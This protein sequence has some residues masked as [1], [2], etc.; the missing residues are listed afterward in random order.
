M[1]YEASSLCAPLSR[2]VPQGSI[3]GLLLFTIY[4]LPRS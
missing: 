4:M 1:I 3:L 2:G